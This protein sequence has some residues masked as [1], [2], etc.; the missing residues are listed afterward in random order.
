MMRRV[1]LCVVLLALGLGGYGFCADYTQHEDFGVKKPGDVVSFTVT[2]PGTV[3]TGGVDS[4]GGFIWVGGPA[5]WTGTIPPDFAGV[6]NG[7]FSGTYQP[8]PGGT[9]GPPHVYTWEADTKAEVVKLETITDATI[10]SDRT[11]RK[12]GVGEKV[13]LTLKGADNSVAWSFEGYG[14]FASSGNSARYTAYERRCDDIV[15]A[16]YKGKEF[17]A[18]FQVVEPTIESAIKLS[19]VSYL[20]PQGV[21]MSLDVTIHPT[22][23]SFNNVEHREV[24]GPASNLTGYF[25]NSIFTPEIL[26]HHPKDWLPLNTLNTITDEPSFEGCPPPWYAGSYQWII[27]VE[28]RVHEGAYVGTLPN[29]VQTMSITDTNGNCIIDKLGQSATSSY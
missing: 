7:S 3:L 11:R 17:Y 4:P 8:P 16:T 2:P 14:I 26:Y 27:P 12:L 24:E 28:W 25:T 23:V 10:P 15:T 18:V 20:T 5:S 6:H 21:G 9:G 29:R 19:E 1:K 22:Y 13:T